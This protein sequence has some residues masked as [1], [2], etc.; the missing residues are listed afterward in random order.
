[1][2]FGNKDMFDVCLTIVVHL[3]YSERKC[4]APKVI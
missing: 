2:N 3:H 4:Y 1:M